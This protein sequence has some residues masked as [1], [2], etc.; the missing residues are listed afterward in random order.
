MMRRRGTETGKLK[1]T[2]TRR[3]INGMKNRYFIFPL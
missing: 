1:T 3:T 2:G